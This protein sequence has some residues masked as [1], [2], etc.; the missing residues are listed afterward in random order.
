MDIR[1]VK[2][3]GQILSCVIEGKITK[4]DDVITIANSDLPKDF[5]VMFS[6]GKYLIKK[7]KIV[8][9]KKFAMSETQPSKV[10]KKTD[11]PKPK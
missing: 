3:N 10:G 8:E 2:E 1:F 11:K 5:L 6:L 9:N 7:G 4:T